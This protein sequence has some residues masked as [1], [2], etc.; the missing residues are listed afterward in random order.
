VRLE[1]ITILLIEHNMEVMNICERII[2]INYGRK[3]AEGSLEEL[4][5]NED[6]IR[7]Y[8]GEEYA[9]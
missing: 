9:A 2:V 5:K 6:V 7:A 4:R 3:I 1:G 8:L